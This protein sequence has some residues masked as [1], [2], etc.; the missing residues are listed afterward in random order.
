[1]EE[2]DGLVVLL[3]G[4]GHDEHISITVGCFINNELELEIFKVRFLI[5]ILKPERFVT[6]IIYSDE[7]A[8]FHS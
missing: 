4:V 6:K 3:E 2:S 8:A 7:I 1:M 5:L